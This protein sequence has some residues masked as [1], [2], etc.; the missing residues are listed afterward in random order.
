MFGHQM[1]AGGPL[2]GSLPRGAKTVS[3]EA[4]RIPPVKIFREGELN[5]DVL[6]VILNNVRMPEMN[7]ADLMGI[8][9]GC[10][11]A[12]KRVHELC[13]RFGKETYL[14]AC[15]AL[16]D[17]TYKAMAKLIVGA[18]PEGPQS[19]EDWDDDD[20]LGHGPYKMR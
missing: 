4:I 9:A 2:P 11:T 7:R 17:R 14:A 16:L 5:T 8:I 3:G 10:R 15:Q 1:D 18:I 20:G 19:F 12:E 6:G 13:S